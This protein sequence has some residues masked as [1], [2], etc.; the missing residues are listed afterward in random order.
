MPD[1]YQL[2]NNS[3][4]LV[5][6]NANR[7]ILSKNNV[8][9]STIITATLPSTLNCS[10]FLNGSVTATWNVGILTSSSTTSGTSTSLTI[11]LGTCFVSYFATSTSF[12]LA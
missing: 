11:N 7:P 12:T 4:S 6:T 1:L 2:A 10:N 9:A 5:I 3:V 8:S